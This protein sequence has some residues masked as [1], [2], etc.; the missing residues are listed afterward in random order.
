VPLLPGKKNQSANISEMVHSYDA[1]GKI[2]HAHPES[3]EKAIKM[4]IAA[5]YAKLGEA[6]ARAKK[7]R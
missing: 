7:A 6:R 5:S 2:G 1:S 3:R 4:A